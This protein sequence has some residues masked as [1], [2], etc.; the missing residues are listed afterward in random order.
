MIIK[1][2]FVIMGHF[3]RQRIK[4]KKKITPDA[5]RTVCNLLGFYVVALNITEWKKKMNKCILINLL[6]EM[7]PNTLQKNF[8][9]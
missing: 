6:Q 8:F 4:K 5:E 9:L 2:V 3:W 7:I 1:I